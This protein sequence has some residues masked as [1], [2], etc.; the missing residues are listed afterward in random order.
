MTTVCLHE[1][2][3]FGWLACYAE[4]CGHGR[5]ALLGPLTADL[6]DTFGVFVMPGWMHGP[7]D[8]GPTAAGQFTLDFIQGKLPGITDLDLQLLGVEDL[9]AAQDEESI[10]CAYSLGLL[11][12]L[13]F[14]RSTLGTCEF[15]I[16]SCAPFLVV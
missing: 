2:T 3:T 15:V 5:E 1:P 8:R 6:P 9:L 10:A 7:G 12:V 16:L 14:V 11:F 4:G 13:L